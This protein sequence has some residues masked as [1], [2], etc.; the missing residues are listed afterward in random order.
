[1]EASVG[2]VFQGFDF[3]LS[4]LF[5]YLF[6][7]LFEIG[8]GREIERDKNSDVREK[9]QF[10]ASLNAPQ[11]GTEPTTQACTLTRNRTSNLSLCGMMPN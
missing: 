4:Y 5:I 10:V 7:Y 6:I 2:Q 9:H 3:Y 11:L 8:V 1:M